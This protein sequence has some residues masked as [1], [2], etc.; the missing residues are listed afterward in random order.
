M[1]LQ[2][3]I[4]PTKNSVELRVQV[5][6]ENASLAD[7]QQEARQYGSVSRQW[8]ERFV[9]AVRAAHGHGDDDSHIGA[10]LTGV[11]TV[12]E[13]SLYDALIDQSVTFLTGAKPKKDV[14][15]HI[16]VDPNE[17][18]RIAALITVGEEINLIDGNV[19]IFGY[20]SWYAYIPKTSLLVRLQF[21]HA[22]VLKRLSDR[23][24]TEL[25]RSFLRELLS[26]SFYDAKRLGRLPL[27]KSRLITSIPTRPV[28][29][30]HLTETS[31][32][33]RAH[34][35]F[36]Y[37]DAEVVHHAPD[38]T[39]TFQSNVLLVL[40]RDSDA[41]RRARMI[42]EE[43]MTQVETYFVPRKDPVLWLASDARTLVE[44][45]FEL[46]GRDAI[47]GG[48]MREETPKLSVSASA[49]MDWLDMKVEITVGDDEIPLKDFMEALMNRDSFIRMRDG[50]AVRIPD[51][52]LERLSDKAAFMQRQGEVL[53][54][55]TAHAELVKDVA[56]LDET[57]RLSPELERAIDKVRSLRR[58]PESEVPENLQATLRPYQKR[59]YDWL[60]FL[61]D[62]GFGGVLADDMGLGKTLQVIT[63]LLDTHTKQTG[64]SIVIAP[65]SLIYNWAKEVEKFAPDLRT[66][67]HHGSGRLATKHALE[68]YETDLVITTYNTLR[69]D[70]WL[71][72]TEF[73]Y[74][75]LDESQAIK[76]AQS[77][78]SKT[79]REVTAMYRIAMTGTP[80]ENSTLELWSQF[81]FAQPG[82]LGTEAH[83]RRFYAKRIEERGDSQR[84]AILKDIIGPF[85]LRRTK[86]EVA[87]DLPSK[88]ISIDYVEMSE[89]QGAMYMAAK[90]A[91]REK[92]EERIESHGVQGSS[93]EILTGLLRLRQLANHP[94]LLDEHSLARSGKFDA[95]IE[96]ISLACSEGHKV[97]VFGTFLKVLKKL[98]HDL[99]DLGIKT[100]YLD[101]STD[102]RMDRVEKFQ[103]DDQTKVFVISLKAGGVGLT[104]T[105]ADYVF[106]ADPWWNPAIEAQA[107]DRAYRI[108]QKRP[109]FVYKMISKDSVEEKIIQLQE[110][111]R[112]VSDAVISDASVLSGLSE[113][114]VKDL[115]S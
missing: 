110:K 13:D 7:I 30:V 75:V 27:T 25:P 81:A 103:E 57:T 12:V 46:F 53:R 56:E 61:R 85:L 105:A 42:L 39:Y 107:I 60:V 33:I 62:N 92:V 86:E 73:L 19:R 31:G 114:D 15:V 11:G 28:P 55:S 84:A 90:A 21:S 67:V 47:L 6:Y 48:K 40:P 23:A 109:V 49:G 89:E 112:A 9:Q 44:H 16:D 38:H 108:G 14:P 22:D 65:T 95:M 100:V 104:L 88:T 69:N 115:F 5:N 101:G 59:G 34:L 63:C 76:N 41:E 94:M 50:S 91:I 87:T 10:V 70:P 77:Q 3:S 32:E 99:E 17:P 80:V 37:G 68:E 83:F 18:D 51:E 71:L 4:T 20:D 29:R 72:E 102:D 52:W 98:Q 93:V 96:Q 43:S 106:I 24:G 45:G 35:R 1:S 2:V 97:L 74:C 26:Q 36:A 54:V 64:K 79:V 78:T 66:Y 58:I 111:K 82:L 113:D 8:I